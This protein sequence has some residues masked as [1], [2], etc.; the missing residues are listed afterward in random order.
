MSVYPKSSL[1]RIGCEGGLVSAKCSSGLWPWPEGEITGDWQPGTGLTIVPRF[2]QRFPQIL[3]FAQQR[4]MEFSG[5]Q[6][7]SLVLQDKVAESS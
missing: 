3:P 5:D 7:R 2:P 6:Y 1:Y 4:A